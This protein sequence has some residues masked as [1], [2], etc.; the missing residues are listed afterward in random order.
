MG[1]DEKCSACNDCTFYSE[2][3]CHKATTVRYDLKRY[4]SR[5]EQEKGYN[6]FVAD[7]LCKNDNSPANPIFIEIFVTH[8]CSLEKRKSGIRI[9]EFLIHS[10]EDILNIVS[11][12]QISESDMIRLYNFKR[13]EMFTD[14]IGR[15]FQKYILYPKLRSYV[16]RHKYTCKNY[17]KSRKGVYEISLPYDDCLPY[18]FN[19]GGLYVVGKVKAYLDGYL[20]KDCQLCKWQ[21][22]DFL[23]ESFC[24]LYKKCGNPKYCKD[25]D[26]LM[27]PMFREDK[28]IIN[29]A[30]SDFN[31]YIKNNQIEVWKADL[32]KM[33]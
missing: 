24:K 19:S 2:T 14:E 17:G 31:D 3:N 12:S 26:V 32:S 25:N 30:I 33:E 23:G 18:F 9:I 16:D 1:A 7:L 5:C 21:S 29:C 15:S 6:G 22:T 4:Y 20:K 13:K 28:E 10:E 11:S 8:E 27:C